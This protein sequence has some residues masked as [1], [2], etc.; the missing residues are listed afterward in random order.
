MLKKALVF[1]A[2]GMLLLL[3]GCDPAEKKTGVEF[4]AQ[5]KNLSAVQE[6][7]TRDSA[8]SSRQM[9]PAESPAI[10]PSVYKIALVNFWLLKEGG[11]AVNLINDNASQPTYTEETPLI[12]DFT[13]NSDPQKLL[14]LD[15]LAPGTYTGYRMQFLYL[16]MQLAVAFHLPAIA[17]ETDLDIVGS[18]LGENINIEDYIDLRL[19][20][21]F[22]LYFNAIGKY[23][24]KDFVVQLLKNR[25]RWFW[26]RRELEDRDNSRNFFISVRNSERH[27]PGGAGPDSIVN[28][29]CDEEF[30]GD[31]ELID[32][33]STPIIVGTDS[34]SGGLDV[35]LEKKFTIP[36]TIDKLYTITMTVDVKDTM[37]FGLPEDLN[38]GV[39]LKDG[40]LNL[41]PGYAFEQY[42]NIGLHPMVPKFSI[43]VTEE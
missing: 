8:A 18:N 4:K 1:L 15:S 3:F 5:A 41:G 17:E 19:S 9:E 12:I 33:S 26:L 10:T 34:D 13:S 32:D 22:R 37:T 36:Q 29:F 31:E 7:E 16:E 43:V 40:V 2:A 27:P 11:E 28:L 20:R 42:G 23:W 39:T 35:T 14:S 25:D 38:A 21:K 6:D 24:K 30:W